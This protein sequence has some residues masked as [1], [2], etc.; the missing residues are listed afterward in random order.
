MDGL[1][2]GLQRFGICDQNLGFGRNVLVVILSREVN[3]SVDESL[4][5][6]RVVG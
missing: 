6:V 2:G 5:I 4:G 3:C 1:G